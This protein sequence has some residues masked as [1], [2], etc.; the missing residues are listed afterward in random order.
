MEEVTLFIC[1]YFRSFPSAAQPAA[2]HEPVY[3]IR[4]P[5][6]QPVIYYR[7]QSAPVP[8]TAGISG[9]SN[10]SSPAYIDRRDGVTPPRLIPAPVMSRGAFVQK[11]Y[12]PYYRQSSRESP[13]TI[14]SSVSSH[15][16]TPQGLRVVSPLY[17]PQQKR[18][19]RH[20]L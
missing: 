6:E 4:N 8:H 20:I 14:N 13:M 17:H 11:P 18:Q 1:V 12:I 5:R 2:Y 19:Y 15:K 3:F 7:Q 9:Y 10:R 16:M